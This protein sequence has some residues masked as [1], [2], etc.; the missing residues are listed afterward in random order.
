[1]KKVFLPYFPRQDD[2]N[3]ERQRRKNP[4]GTETSLPLGSP[5]KNPA[6]TAV[7]IRDKTPRK[8]GLGMRAGPKEDL[9][10]LVKFPYRSI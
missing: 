6:R 4:R 7:S 2:Q 10:F 9:H 5:G 1:M 3:Q 8:L